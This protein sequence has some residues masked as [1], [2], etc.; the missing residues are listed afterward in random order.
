MSDMS[1][2]ILCIFIPSVLMRQQGGGNQGISHFPAAQGFTPTL[3]ESGR[4]GI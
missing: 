2:A 3:L 1:G 4:A